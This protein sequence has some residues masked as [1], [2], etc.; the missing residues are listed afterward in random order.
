MV[1]KGRRIMVTK[2]WL[3]KLKGKGRFFVGSLLD[4]EEGRI[5]A[6]IS[7]KDEATVFSDLDKEGLDL[8][9]WG[10]ENTEW[11]NLGEQGVR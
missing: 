2:G 3:L 5:D 11:V 9:T 8:T 6:W 4:D 10:E 1:T 7:N